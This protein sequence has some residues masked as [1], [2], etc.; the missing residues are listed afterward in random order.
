[1]STENFVQQFD[2]VPQ[3][4]QFLR[5]LS[6]NDLIIELIQNELDAKASHTSIA[7]Y[8]DRLVCQGNGEPVT[9]SGWRRL[10]YVMGAGDQIESK[11]F[12]IGVKNH[13]LKACFKLG[14]EIILRSDGRRMIQTLYKDGLS[15]QPSPGTLL[16]PVLDAEAPLT[17]CSVEVPFRTRKLVVAKGEPFELM[18][19][20]DAFPERL[21][22]DACEQLSR[23][24]LGIVRPGIRDQ[25]TLSLSHHVLGS[26]E[27]HW[28]AKRGKTVKGKG[29]R[30]YSL[31]NRECNT[32]S[33]VPDVPSETIREQAIMFRVPFPPGTSREIADFFAQG[34]R[35]FLA[36]IAWLTDKRLNPK[37]T[38]GI[39]RYP[40]GYDNSSESALTGAGV[41]FSGPYRSD[42]ERHGVSE[43]APINGHIDNAC[44]EALV[45]IMASYLL[46]KHGA[47]VLELYMADPYR[48]NEESLKDL[49]KR[50]IE[51]RGVPL[52]ARTLRAATQSKPTPSKVHRKSPARL[53]L[54]PRRS[55]DG[56]TR[57]I[58][59]PMFTWDKERTSPLLSEVC[60]S[61]E[62]QIDSRVPG[63]ILRLLAR[64]NIRDAMTITF[65]EKDAIGRLQP[66]LDSE[67]LPFPWSGEVEWKAS[68]GNPGLSKRY[69]DVV[70]ETIQAGHL[71]SEQDIL[72][73]A[74][75]PDES[76]TA[77]PLAG[78][79]SAVNLPPDL[80]ER[81]F[82]PILHTEVRDHRLLARRAWRLKPFTLDDYL[83]T[84]QLETASLESRK[85]FW[86]WLRENWRSVQ[87]KTLQEIARLP[88]W[89]NTD[90]HLLPLEALCEP[91]VARVASIMNKTI[92]RPS[93]DILEAG[94]FNSRGTR[95]LRLRSVPTL[96]EVEGFLAAS[97]KAYPLER[98]LTSTERRE[99]HKF[100]KDLSV[101]VSIPELRKYLA[102]LSIKYAVALATDG[103]LKSPHKL[104]RSEG[105]TSRLHLPA[106][107]II[108]R[109][110][111]EL[112]RVEGWAPR[113]SPATDQIVDAIR[114]DANRTDV[115]IP[116][117]QEYV[118]Q[119][120]KEGLPPDGV[121][122]LPC[123]PMPDGKLSPPS[124]IA[125]RGKRDF[126]GEWKEVL[127]VTGVN[128]EVQGLYTKIGVVG[129]ELDAN[130]SWQFFRWLSSQ[131]PQFIASHIN[132]VLRHIGHRAGPRAWAEEYPMVPFIPVEADSEGVRLVTRV[133]ATKTGS[134]VV[135]PDFESLE[136]EIRK[137]EGRRP[138]NL[139]VVESRRVIEPITGELRN[140]GLKTLSGLAG[141]PV[142][143]VG[144]GHDTPTPDLDFRYILDSLRS[145][146]KGQ[147]LRKRLDSLDFDTRQNKLKNNWRERLLFIQDVKTADSVSATYRLSRTSFYVPVAGKFDKSTGVL[148]LEAGPDIQQ[149][150][151]DVIGDHIFDTPQ[152]YLG[153]VL[154][155]AYRMEVRERNPNLHTDDGDPIDDVDDDGGSN[156]SGE[157]DG[158]LSATSGTHS[159]PKPDPSR[160]F[161]K[162][163][164]IPTGPGSIK[165]GNNA[166]RTQSNRPQSL[167]E[168]AQIEDVKENQY[169]WHCQ[170]CLSTI[171]PKLLAPPSSYVEL[172]HNR[173]P[174]MHAHHCDQ[175]HAGGARH[176]G[177]LLLLCSFHHFAFGDAVS[178]VEVIQSLHQ[179]TEMTLTFS[180]DNGVLRDVDGNIAT[181]HPPQRPAPFSLFFTKQHKDY[182]LTK[183]SEE[184]L[185]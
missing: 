112:D 137:Q 79:F 97:C 166:N 140:L 158:G 176:A 185:I 179:A 134:E 43:Q 110:T 20:E 103:T 149:T 48:P 50:T 96:S 6:S 73:N 86:R 87:S 33:T 144:E 177:N 90:G 4:W 44:R 117:I 29:G 125:L 89:P 129:G 13:G 70:Y 11:Q 36:E 178:R 21:F 55:S 81:K 68:L 56:D 167:E 99:F 67:G 72:Q 24:L 128:A 175:V 133:E 108:Y 151:F 130:N 138:V 180:G 105:T 119:A 71:D 30:Q 136:V 78:M 41:Y 28:R 170:V 116:R 3:F 181:I 122:D 159:V 121:R 145:G 38:K 114:Q 124:Q 17:G 165:N 157:A 35:S 69:L 8:S 34:N 27:F 143:V 57:W 135:I 66:R 59:L 76:C 18:P 131:T 150:F 16:N 74:F 47:K 7:F 126:W 154:H 141:E 22:R 161:P 162:P 58:V 49:V 9:E 83:A 53:P 98:P 46:H 104:V 107:H 164:P 106:R 5:G 101:L 142:R 64:N 139:A 123:I 93:S 156:D 15:E 51:K 19:T 45:D 26:A 91:K 2:V 102:E 163:G 37:A 23:R 132:Q 172:H 169:A 39:R 184:G 152:R 14:D 84:A 183:A 148:W 160:N 92:R 80:G 60:P 65:D 61:G 54:G 115:H 95:Q 40:I 182:W 127:P 10:A 155:R 146:A 173:Q 111:R 63:P 153:S 42:A 171:E 1:M 94:L 109:P 52:Q 85:S 31:F 75:L 32:F 113:P 82:V 88:I 77:Q 25:F 12:S 147:Q 168:N 174:I 120:A 62:D 100:E 118:K